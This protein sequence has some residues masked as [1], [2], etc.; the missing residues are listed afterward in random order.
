MPTRND[1]QPTPSPGYTRYFALGVLLAAALLAWEFLGPQ[2]G[3]RRI[4][5]SLLSAARATID[6]RRV[7]ESGAEAYTNIVFLHHSTGEHL[8]QA[9]ELRARLRTQGYL[10]WDHGYNFQGLRD[11]EGIPTGYSYNIPNNN[12]D[13]QGLAQVFNQPELPLPVNALSGL[14]QHDVIMLKSCF[15]PTSEIADEA[16]LETYQ[17]AYR[18]MRNVIARHPEK[19]FILLTQ[20]PLNPA[21]TDSEQAA[22]ARRLADWLVSEDFQAGLPNLVVFDLFDRL[23]ESDPTSPDFSMLSQEYRDGL[24]SHPNW[25]ASKTIA[26]ELADYIV[27]AIENYRQDMQPGT[28]SSSSSS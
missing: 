4:G 7:R 21:S 10:L 15:T 28:Y 1:L 22:R 20:P 3:P 19:L 17:Q 16:Q 8:I 23:A 6:S 2:P 24:D 14:L 11:P 12:T 25:I 13:P 18:E 26:P 9:G 5:R 27:Q